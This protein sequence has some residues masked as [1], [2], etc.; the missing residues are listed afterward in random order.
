MLLNVFFV[1]FTSVVY[2][3]KCV[4][5]DVKLLSR[6]KALKWAIIAL[7]KPGRT[8]IFNRNEK[9]LEKIKPFSSKHNITILIFSESIFSNDATKLFKEKFHGIADV[10]IINTSDRGFN[11]QEKFGYK[12]MCKF[13]SLDVYDYLKDNYDYYIRC[14]T[15]CFI[16]NL[17]YDIFDWTESNKVEYGFAMRKIEAHKP[18]AKT[19]PAFT[20]NYLDKC[21][22]SAK[23]IMDFPLSTCFNFYNNFHIGKVS[24]FT[25][26]DVQHYLRTVNS[27][28]FILSHRWGDSTIQAYAVRLFMDISAIKQIPDFSYVHGSHNRI[29]STFGDGSATNVPQRLP[30]WK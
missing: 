7:A 2:C 27:S 17:N 26:P 30:N 22:I 5:E 25:R 1:L 29:V 24:F 4:N 10:K 9:I 11:L 8:D 6:N 23:S 15:D 3:N 21:D 18:T 19:L 14:D 20:L 13:F 16:S 12:Y 28:G